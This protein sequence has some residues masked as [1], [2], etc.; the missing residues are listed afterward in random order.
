MTLFV[1]NQVYLFF[2]LILSTKGLSG[3]SLSF[4]LLLGMLSFFFFEG[5]ILSTLEVLF[6]VMI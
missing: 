1:F 6:L 3:T 5:G 4:L 2:L